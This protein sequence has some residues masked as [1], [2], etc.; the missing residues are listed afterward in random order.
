MRAKQ[1]AGL[2]KRLQ[3]S[4][5][6]HEP[7]IQSDKLQNPADR[8]EQAQRNLQLVFALVAYRR[9][10]GSYPGKLDELSPNYLAKIPD[11][12]FSGKPLVYRLEGKGILLYSVGPN[13]V[14]E[15]GRGPDDDPRGDDLSVR[16]PLPRPRVKD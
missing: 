12:L 5:G 6:W 15:G 11:D 9:D 1:T 3:R 8:S 13:G 16:L 10:H 7:L 2:E 4:G 14:D